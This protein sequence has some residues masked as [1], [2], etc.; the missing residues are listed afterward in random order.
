MN[1]KRAPTADDRPL[2]PFAIGFRLPVVA[3]VF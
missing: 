3:V 1:K 2:E